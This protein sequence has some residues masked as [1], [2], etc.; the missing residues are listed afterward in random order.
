MNIE[1]IRA[2]LEQ[3]ATDLEMGRKSGDPPSF[4]REILVP[5]GIALAA[6]LIPLWLT[7]T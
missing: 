5:I 7:A 2:E 3:I 4:C 6:V 1:H